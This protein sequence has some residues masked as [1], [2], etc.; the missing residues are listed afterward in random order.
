MH[1]TGNRI[2]TDVFLKRIAQIVD[3]IVK[4]SVGRRGRVTAT[5]LVLPLPSLHTVYNN[6]DSVL[7][8]FRSLFLTAQTTPVTNNLYYSGNNTTC[9][10]VHCMM[11]KGNIDDKRNHVFSDI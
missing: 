2:K 4:N 9:A 3:L 1:F 8:I 11:T 7:L 5:G 6:G 10:C